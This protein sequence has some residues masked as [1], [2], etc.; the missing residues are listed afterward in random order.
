MT[1]LPGSETVENPNNSHVN[2]LTPKEIR[3]VWEGGAGT[4]NF[5]RQH[6][7]TFFCYSKGGGTG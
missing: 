2:A 4:R 5:C 3:K 6:I 1:S 7:K